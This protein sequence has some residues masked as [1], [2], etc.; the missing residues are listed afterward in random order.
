[1]ST[2]KVNQN[3]F[4]YILFN[5]VLG[6]GVPTAL[7]FQLI[8]HFAGEKDFFDGIF[9]SLIIFPITGILFGYFM[10]KFTQ[11]KTDKS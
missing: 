5:G 7:L 11:N 9:S 8:M 10:W 6:W 3:L 1:M 4:R 2:K